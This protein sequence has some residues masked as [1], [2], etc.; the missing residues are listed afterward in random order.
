MQTDSQRDLSQQTYSRVLC[1][2]SY[3]QLSLN[4]STIFQDSNA[5]VAFVFDIQSEKTSV[6]TRRETPAKATLSLKITETPFSKGQEDNYSLTGLT[7]TL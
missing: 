4:I 1:I 3:A 7:P 2:G 6:P 5:I